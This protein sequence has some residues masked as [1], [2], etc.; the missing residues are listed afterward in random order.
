MDKGGK[1]QHYTSTGHD[2]VTL[3]SI[4]WNPFKKILHLGNLD[5]ATLA[6]T[7]PGLE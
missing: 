4:V 3:I 1:W 2:L 7:A 5:C 6:M